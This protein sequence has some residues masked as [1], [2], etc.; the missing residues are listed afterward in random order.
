M[1][2]WQRSVWLVWL[3]FFCVATPV[4]VSAAPADSKAKAKLHFDLG[5]SYYDAG[6]YKQAVVEYEEA[7]R[8]LPLP[9]FLF[10]IA[11]AY[12]LDGN[13]VAAIEYYKRY[14]LHDPDGRGADEARSILA[15]L[16]PPTP[17]STTTP[18]VELPRVA[19]PPHTAE[20][21]R[22]AEP[23]R[24]VEPQRTEDR[25]P[26]HVEAVIAAPIVDRPI[27]KPVYRRGWFWA[28][29]GGSVALVGATIAIGV[30]FGRAQRDPVPSM[31]TFVAA[32]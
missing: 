27:H 16:A 22:I 3:I 21:P 4:A 28:A 13:R 25:A 18:V 26:S 10:N 6:E 32:P 8:A 20:P 19:E 24:A 1:D 29:V 17:Q 31:G 7:Y 12:R 2:L 5:K 11:Q 15:E 9:D 23:A 30:V 14:L